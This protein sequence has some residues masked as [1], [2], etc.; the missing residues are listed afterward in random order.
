MQGS[1]QL[2]HPL[3]ALSQKQGKRSTVS[4]QQAIQVGNV[5]LQTQAAPIQVVSTEQTIEQRRQAQALAVDMA[6][7]AWETKAEDVRVID[8]EVSVKWTTFFVILTVFSRPQLNAI[9]SKMVKRAREHWEMDEVS[10]HNG[11][12]AW[13]A[14]DFGEVV[15]HAF[16]AQ[17]REYY[18]LE[19][20]F[21]D[22]PEVELNFETQAQQQQQGLQW[23]TKQSL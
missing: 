23:S 11:K 21:E 7:V 2:F 5:T 19:S 16:S 18:D 6:R 15:I 20:K 1:L 22:C 14:L 17:M 12:S 10:K 9:L 13:E 4:K 3:P 8:V